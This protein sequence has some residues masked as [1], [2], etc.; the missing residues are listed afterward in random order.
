MAQIKF[1]DKVS[2]ELYEGIAD[3]S[4]EKFNDYEETF[5]TYDMSYSPDKFI[6]KVTT[7]REIIRERNPEIMSTLWGLDIKSETAKFGKIDSPNTLC[8]KIK[9]RCF[10]EAYKII[11]AD[12]SEMPFN[13]EKHYFVNYNDIEE[14]LY[15]RGDHA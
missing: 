8:F 11:F 14:E 1:E 10:P 5:D 6:V 2:Y 9:D 4:P 3:E 13:A 12:G 15:V 7:K